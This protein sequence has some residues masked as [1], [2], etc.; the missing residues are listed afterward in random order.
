MLKHVS[1]DQE[2]SYSDM[3]EKTKVIRLLLKETTNFE[4]ESVESKNYLN[5]YK[6]DLM[7]Y[8]VYRANHA[9]KVQDYNAAIGCLSRLIQSL[10]TNYTLKI[11]NQETVLQ[12][13]LQRNPASFEQKQMSPS[14]VDNNDNN[15]VK[16]TNQNI[17][18]D[19]SFVEFE[20]MFLGEKLIQDTS[21][22]KQLGE[23]FFK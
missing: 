18:K 7:G 23:L 19:D 10:T 8:F 4:K 16:K 6:K 22:Y 3:Y 20:S 2:P 21:D 14:A 12:D 11:L 17:F 15:S 1:S 13:F 5:Q 9:S